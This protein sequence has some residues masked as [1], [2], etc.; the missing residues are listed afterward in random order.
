MLLFFR[1]ILNTCLGDILSTKRKLQSFWSRNDVALK[2]HTNIEQP[3]IG[4]NNWSRCLLAA[5]N[6]HRTA[7]V[8]QWSVHKSRK[9]HSQCS[10]S[11]PPIRRNPST[12]TKIPSTLNGTLMDGCSARVNEHAIAV[13]QAEN[14]GE[15]KIEN[16]WRLRFLRSLVYRY[17]NMQSDRSLPSRSTTL[18]SWQK[19][20]NQLGGN[21][22]FRVVRPETNDLW[23]MSPGRFWR[24][25]GLVKGEREPR[26]D[27]ACR[28]ILGL[29]CGASG[30]RVCVRGN[31]NYYHWGK[32]ILRDHEA[33]RTTMDAVR[34]C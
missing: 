5:T 24:A 16:C 22:Q 13:S 2:M 3:P 1:L 10:K 17:R 34:S 21:M 25:S 20:C 19:R 18:S 29:G 30:H 12:G 8:R 23:F 9:L 31:I 28:T 14:L 27:L 4:V 7:S 33:L 26:V 15:V 32:L 6:N 11:Q